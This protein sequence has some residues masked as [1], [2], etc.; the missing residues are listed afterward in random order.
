MKTLLAVIIFSG[1]LAGALVPAQEHKHE[2]HKDERKVP[3][4]KGT[5]AVKS[6]SMK[7]CEGIDKMDDVKS[8]MPMKGDMKYKM[9]KMKEMKDKMAEKM[10]MKTAEGGRPNAENKSTE[11]KDAEKNPHQH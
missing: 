3:A 1:A 8:G 10:K 11:L 6:D 2:E 7:C 4:G 5:D 9:E